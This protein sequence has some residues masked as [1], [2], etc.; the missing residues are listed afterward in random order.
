MTAEELVDWLD[1]HGQFDQSPLSEWFDSK[2]CQNCESIKI[3]YEEAQ[4][5]LGFSPYSWYNIDTECAYCEL[6]DEC[7]VKRCRFFPDIEDI[8][9]NKT[10]IK[11]WLEEEAHEKT[12]S[13]N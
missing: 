8:P 10:I 1:E 2:Y 4:E 13:C 5:K 7:G 12:S 11:L 6:S 9:D 3:K